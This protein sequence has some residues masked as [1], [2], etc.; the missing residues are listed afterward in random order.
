MSVIELMQW[1]RGH[2]TFYKRNVLQ[3]LEG[4]APEIAGRD[5]AAPQGAPSPSLPQS[6]QF[7]CPP[8]LMPIIC[9]LVP[10]MLLAPSEQRPE[11]P[12][13]QASHWAS[14]PSC[15]VWQNW[16][17]KVVCAGHNHL[18][19]KTKSGDDWGY[20]HGNCNHLSGRIGTQ[21]SPNGSSLSGT[22]LSEEGSGTPQHCHRGSHNKGPGERLPI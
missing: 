3:N 1:V 13:H 15:P 10:Q 14:R 17:R 16:R 4:A 2:I 18:S 12:H 22:H 20:S 21:E 8:Q 7:P 19:E 11:F 6:T 5:P 9:Q